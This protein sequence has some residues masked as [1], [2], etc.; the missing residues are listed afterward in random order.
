MSATVKK[1]RVTSKIAQAENFNLPTSS[2]S[3]K[4]LL[5]QTEEKRQIL[6]EKCEEYEKLCRSER[7]W[8]NSKLEFESTNNVF[9]FQNQEID[10]KLA[11]IL[12]NSESLFLSEQQ[13]LNEAL[14][15]IK[16]Y[17]DLVGKNEKIERNL[18]KEIDVN[19][20]MESSCLK[21]REMF[22]KISKKIEEHGKEIK[23]LEMG[24][25]ADEKTKVTLE[26]Y[27]S[28]LVEDVFL[29]QR[30]LEDIM[31][32]TSKNRSNLR[33][34]EKLLRAQKQRHQ[35]FAKILGLSKNL[36]ISSENLQ[37]LNYLRNLEEEWL[38]LQME[39][40][41]VEKKMMEKLEVLKNS[42]QVMQTSK[43]AEKLEMKRFEKEKI[44]QN[45]FEME[46]NTPMY[47]AYTAR[48]SKNLNFEQNLESENQSETGK[49]ED[50]EKYGAKSVRFKYDSGRIQEYYDLLDYRKK[51]LRT[52]EIEAIQNL[53][54]ELTILRNS[55]SSQRQE[56]L[57]LDKEIEWLHE[58]ILNRQN[59]IQTWLKKTD[60]FLENAEKERLKIEKR[61]DFSHISSQM[62]SE[63]LP[64]LN[65]EDLDEKF[66]Y[67][68]RERNFLKDTHRNLKISLNKLEQQWNLEKSM[69]FNI[70]NDFQNSPD[71]SE[72][73]A[74]I[75]Q[76]EDQIKKIQMMENHAFSANGVLK[77]DLTLL[78]PYQEEYQEFEKLVDQNNQLN[79]NL[80]KHNLQMG[81]QELQDSG[82]IKIF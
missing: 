72:W 54:K 21:N 33:Q 61:E 4:N 71:V 26:K 49:S 41:K 1:A 78:K 67:L 10:Q 20:Q 34:D 58:N 13:K 44:A 3:T 11:G 37:D 31:L 51:I 2:E 75:E 46:K 35:H 81:S 29:I 65:S 9:N 55:V 47:A 79:L 15:F 82:D 12:Q 25:E 14:K 77:S 66:R 23:K 43:L 63:H 19:E 68:E 6:D 60:D 40:E 28:R 53:S 64:D 80:A 8:K 56:T 32:G 74:K 42:K 22:S 18:E 36:K 76:I 45:Y 7:K 5:R 73:I 30:R 62:D 39:V 48:R 50:S 17:E 38:E 16:K 57:F 24:L 59:D 27:F 70:E 69:N 52:S